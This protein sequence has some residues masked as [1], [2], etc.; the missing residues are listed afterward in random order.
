MTHREI[1]SLV[2]QHVFGYAWHDY[3]TGRGRACRVLC[4]PGTPKPLKNLPHGEQVSGPTTDA[5][6]NVVP[7]IPRVVLVGVPRYS[8][9]WAAAGTLHDHLAADWEIEAW[10]RL[11]KTQV[12]LLPRHAPP[13]R[14][15]ATDAPAPMALCLA[16]LSALGVPASLTEEVQ[17]G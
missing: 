5:D 2:A 12:I 9:E 7:L 4:P 14:G 8:T 6:C 17:G 1:D 15:E 13:R 10:T 3:T 11:G 16:A